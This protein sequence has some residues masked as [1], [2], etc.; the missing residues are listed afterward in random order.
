M[1]ISLE[2]RVCQ[3]QFAGEVGQVS[4]TP[5]PVFSNRPVCPKCG[6]RTNDQLWLTEQGQSELTEL[7]LNS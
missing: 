1:Y 4:F 2:C 7:Y 3:T 5:E 6:P